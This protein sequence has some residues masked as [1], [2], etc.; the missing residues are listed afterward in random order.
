MKRPFFLVLLC[1]MLFLAP[2]CKSEST[3]DLK[4]ETA[5]AVIV[6]IA[7]LF[8]ILS[9]YTNI[10]RD[11]VS[12][13]VE[14]NQN[15]QLQ[16]QKQKW[17]MVNKTAPFSLTKVQFGLWTVIISSVY[18]YLSLCKGDCAAAPINQTALALMGI[19]A[20][21]AVASSFMDKSEMNDNRPRHQN[22]PSQGFFIDILS[23][24]NGISLHRFQNLAWTII[25]IIVYL[26]KTSEI[27]AGCELPEL[28]NT[29]LAL[30]GLSSATYLALK[31][32][33]NDPPA[34]QPAS[35]NG[36]T[37]N[38]QTEKPA[39]APATQPQSGN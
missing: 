27:T 29:L 15:A 33:E 39:E 36:N 7:G 23:D 5:V 3:Y 4:C 30:T 21:T 8:V 6:L 10:L 2:G 19:F 13:I 32:K 26:Y 28:S 38:V 9:I 1:S 24:D 31:A 16:Q 17:K 25:A 35:Q 11:E 22:S 18:I 20:G 37:D 34:I 14:F 12:N